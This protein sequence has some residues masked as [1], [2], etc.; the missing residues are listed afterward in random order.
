MICTWSGL[1]ATART[2]QSRQAAA[3]SKKPAPVRAV[4]S[5]ALSRSQ[6]KR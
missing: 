3:S 5:K 2:S 1:P 4:S 6:Q